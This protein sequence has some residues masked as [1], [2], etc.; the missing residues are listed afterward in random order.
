[1]WSWT[2]IIFFL[3]ATLMVVSIVGLMLWFFFIRSR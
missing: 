2:M 1:M 3:L